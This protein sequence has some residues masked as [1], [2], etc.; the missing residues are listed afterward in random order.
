MG[1]VSAYLD[2]KKNN[3]RPTQ[4]VTLSLAKHSLIANDLVKYNNK[5]RQKCGTYPNSNKKDKAKT[6]GHEKCLEES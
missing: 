6:W 4:A 1:H 5:M 2:S 3:H